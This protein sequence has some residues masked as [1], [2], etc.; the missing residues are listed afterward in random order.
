MTRLR[1]PDGQRLPRGDARLS[2]TGAGGR[3][4]LTALLTHPDALKAFTQAEASALDADMRRAETDETLTVEAQG[5]LIRAA[6]LRQA[7]LVGLEVYAADPDV[8]FL[9]LLDDVSTTLGRL[10]PPGGRLA[11]AQGAAGLQDLER[12][13][14]LPEEDQHAVRL[15]LDRAGPAG[16]TADDAVHARL[17][18]AGYRAPQVPQSPLTPLR[19]ALTPPATR[20]PERMPAEQELR[21]LAQSALE[22]ERNA[23]LLL[24]TVNARDRLENAPLIGVLDLTLVLLLTLDRHHQAGGTDD[25][26]TRRLRHWHAELHAQL[27]QPDLPRAKQFRRR[28]HPDLPARTRDARRRL[29][30]LRAARRGPPSAREALSRQ[31]LWT[32]LD[33]L[34]ALLTQGL[35]PEA[36]PDLKAHL[37]LTTLLALTSVARAPG[38]SLPVIVETAARIAD[39]DPLWAWQATQPPE[40]GEGLLRPELD[41]TVQAL[42][43][44]SHLTGTPLGARAHSTLRLAAG[45]LLATVR[46]AGLRLPGQTFLETYFQRFGPLQALPLTPARQR[47]LRAELVTLL[48]ELAAEAQAAAADERSAGDEAEVAASHVPEPVVDVRPPSADETD[49]DPAEPAHVRAARALLAGRRVVLLGGVPSPSHHAALTRSLHLSELDWI[50]SDAYAHGTHARAHVTPDTALVILAVRWM[51][52]AHS[53]LRDVAQDLHVPFVMHPGGLSPSSVAWQVM[54]QVSRQLGAAAH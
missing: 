17:R 32:S 9:E 21:Q 11:L 40:T 2:V 15:I 18:W 30:A 4:D 42:T 48:G 14:L 26:V 6:L 25:A 54:H 49:L 1:G 36:D 33:H 22:G 3:V 27:G 24:L 41:L 20:V 47:H 23:A 45:H 7:L 28:P 53:T 10:G 16:V 38:M 8:L 37:T 51:G 12:V 46:R 19:A 5:T 50:G 31:T 13:P 52:H 43:V 39:L 35:D 44:T 29:R 34:D